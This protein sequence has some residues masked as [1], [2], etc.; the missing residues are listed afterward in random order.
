MST[1]SNDGQE[2]VL[3]VILV[4]RMVVI[5][6]ALQTP[7]KEPPLPKLLTLR[8]A[9]LGVRTQSGETEVGVGAMT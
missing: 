5:T 1:Q 9:R 4:I 8:P 2:T 3:V 7:P 6:A